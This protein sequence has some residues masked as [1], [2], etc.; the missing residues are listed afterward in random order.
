M[1]T[2]ERLFTAAELLALSHDTKRYELVEGKLIEMAPTG[3]SHG[4]LTTDILG[5]SD[6]WE[7]GNVLP[8]FS[9]K[10]ANILA[11]LSDH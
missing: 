5:K 9:L 2:Q 7:G 6:T 1:T 8:G 10:I 11:V 4:L 3:E